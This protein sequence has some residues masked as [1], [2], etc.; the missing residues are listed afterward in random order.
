MKWWDDRSE[1]MRIT[2]RLSL[3]VVLI[4]AVIH[5]PCKHAL[6]KKSVD[7]LALFDGQHGK[8]A[9]IIGFCSCNAMKNK[10]T[11]DKQTIKKKT[12]QKHKQTLQS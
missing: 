2:K 1:L 10:N 6:R 8:N 4:F 9:R 11:Q 7:D 12:K 5:S 3:R